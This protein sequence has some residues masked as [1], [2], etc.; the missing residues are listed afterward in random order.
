MDQLMLKPKPLF[1][2]VMPTYE[3]VMSL[4]RVYDSLKVQTIRD[5]E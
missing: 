4:H 5:F 3:R 1:I 2:V